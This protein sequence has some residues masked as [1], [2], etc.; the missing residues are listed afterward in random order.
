MPE[1]RSALAGHVRPGRFG[2]GSPRLT[3]SERP[4]GTLIQICGWDD[5]FDEAATTMMQRFGFAGLGAFDTAQEQGSSIAFR[6]A[7]RR[8]LIRLKD[9]GVWEEIHA[10]IDSAQLG[11]LDLS[12]ARVLIGI[13]GADAAELLKRLLPIDVE[14]AVFAV[15]RFVQ[16]GLHGTS[17]LLHRRADHDAAL[18]FDLHVPRSFAASIWDFIAETA[19]PFGYRVVGRDAEP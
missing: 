12:H 7:P 13:A 9:R 1:P 8:I 11:S 18:D 4:L 10:S 3:L 17:V 15:G 16:S 5:G 19:L 6:T 2:A 14:P